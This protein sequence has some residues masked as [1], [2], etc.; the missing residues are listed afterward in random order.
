MKEN[1]WLSAKGAIVIKVS[2]FISLW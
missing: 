1:E 2:K